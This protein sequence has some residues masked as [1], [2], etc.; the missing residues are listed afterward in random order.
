MRILVV[1]DE[2]EIA[3]LL[4]T[5]LE[6]QDAVVDHVTLLADAEE[7]ARQG[8]HDAV[9]LDRRLP[10]GDGLTLVPRLRARGVTTPVIVL[11]ARRD[12]ADR[13][14]GLD[15]GADDYLTKP[16]ALEE[17]LARLRT[18]LRRPSGLG[19][20]E[21][22][23][24]TLTFN[25]LHRSASVRGA[26][27][28]LSRRELLV[29]EALVRRAGRTVARTALEEAVYGFAEEIQQNALDPHV[30]RLRRKLGDAGAD[31]EIR[32]VRGVGYLLRALP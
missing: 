26:P 30:S 13:I 4:R 28:G 15:S 6:R 5:A 25:M 29:L 9:I 18:V 27:V 22:A 20:A 16:F 12:L 10:D 8:V 24:G 7:A 3:A 11:T 1:E 31:I 23:V 14:E 2:P 21:V 17:L 32:S 19:E